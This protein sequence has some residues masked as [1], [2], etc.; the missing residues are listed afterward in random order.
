MRRAAMAVHACQRELL[1]V[2]TATAEAK[3]ARPSPGGGGGRTAGENFWRRHQGRA[4]AQ[5][6][7]PLTPVYLKL[8]F[9]TYL[10]LLIF[11]H[12]R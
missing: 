10:L 7:L 3:W 1:G 2:L 5:L 6:P 4:Q 8:Y 11:S 9:F 12:T